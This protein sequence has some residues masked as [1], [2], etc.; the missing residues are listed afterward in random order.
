MIPERN[1]GKFPMVHGPSFRY[2]FLFS[3]LVLISLCSAPMLAQRITGDIAGEVTDSTGAVLPNVT[4]TAIK[5][6]PFSFDYYLSISET[7]C[8]VGLVLP[9]GATCVVML[10]SLG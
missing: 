3:L 9:P 1:E 7:T 5:Y 6:S 2:A 10:R 4:I 8:A